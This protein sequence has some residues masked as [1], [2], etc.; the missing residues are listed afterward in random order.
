MLHLKL[1]EKER[2]SEYTFGK[3]ANG[4]QQTRHSA[5]PV[6]ELLTFQI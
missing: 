4:G 2:P 1:E 5:P 3:S 6:S